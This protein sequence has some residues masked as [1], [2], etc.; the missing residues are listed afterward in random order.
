MKNLEAKEIKREDFE[1]RFTGTKSSFSSR[2]NGKSFYPTIETGNI[3]GRN[4]LY[5]H[6][7]PSDDIDIN[8]QIFVVVEGTCIS[9]HGLRISSIMFSQEDFN[10]NTAVKDLFKRFRY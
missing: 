4:I 8:I 6:L 9:V 7:N 3:S 1:V 2:D 10:I 5:Y